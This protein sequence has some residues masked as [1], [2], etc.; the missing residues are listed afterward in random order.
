MNRTLTERNA[1]YRFSFSADPNALLTIKPSRTMETTGDIFDPEHYLLD[2]EK[3]IVYRKERFEDIFPE[4]VKLR[5][6][7]YL[8]MING[9]GNNG[10]TR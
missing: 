2:T 6:H 4:Y 3:G 1:K 10:I 7:S 5:T 8:I 9:L